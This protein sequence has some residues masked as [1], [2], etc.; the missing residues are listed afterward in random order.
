MMILWLNMAQSCSIHKTLNIPQHLSRTAEHLSHPGT[1]YPY[2]PR[3]EHVIAA[4]IPLLSIWLNGQ[5]NINQKMYGQWR[6]M[7][8]P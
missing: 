8:I 1:N 2:V 4:S 7:V 6:F 5:E 3:L